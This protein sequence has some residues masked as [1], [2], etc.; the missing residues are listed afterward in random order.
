MSIKTNNAIRR[1]SAFLMAIMI[2]LSSMPLNAFA[3]GNDKSEETIDSILRIDN[4]DGQ[5]LDED[6]KLPPV[7]HKVEFDSNG[8][9]GSMDTIEVEHGEKIIVPKNKFNPPSG[10]EFTSWDLEGKDIKEGEEITV[11]KDLTLKAKF[12]GGGAE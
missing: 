1:V 9:T 7:K 12:A 11:N 2:L 8:G 4:K 3:Q 6:D 5:S 10:K